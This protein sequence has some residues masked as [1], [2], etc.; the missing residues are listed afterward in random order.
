[1]IQIPSRGFGGTDIARASA[2]CLIFPCPVARAVRIALI[3]KA[4]LDFDSYEY[5]E[6]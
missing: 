3:H 2:R 4:S 5:I 6:M 1:M